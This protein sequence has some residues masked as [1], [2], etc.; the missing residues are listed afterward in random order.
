M[1]EPSQI[2]APKSQAIADLVLVCDV[3]CATKDVSRS[4]VSRAIFDRSGHIADMAAGLRDISTSTFERSLAWFSENWPQGAAWPDSIER[5]AI[6]TG[7]PQVG[8]FQ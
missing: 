5:P 4:A 7:V 3:Y 6:N 1:T 2:L 8:S